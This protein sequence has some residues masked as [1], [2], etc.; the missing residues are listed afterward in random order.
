LLSSYLNG[1]K[2][3]TATAELGFE[4]TTLDMEGNVTKTAPFDHVTVVAIEEALPDFHGKIKQVPPIFSALRV[5]G[6]K[7][8]QLAREGVS[9]EDIEIKEREVNIHSMDL[10]PGT[11]ALP[12]F[13]VDIECGGGT[14]V[15]SLVR[16]L[17]YKLDTVATMVKLERTKQGQFTRPMCLEKAD[18]NPDNVYSEIE[19]F[20][21]MRDTEEGETVTE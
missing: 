15:R 4:T 13:D 17:G 14:Y 7:L 10:I 12:R 6:K 9:A 2:R 5:N 21:K 19:K 3:Y 18:W 1:S 20:N 8:Y 16:D 11:I